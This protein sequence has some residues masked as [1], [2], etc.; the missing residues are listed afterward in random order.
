MYEAAYTDYI[1]A[2]EDESE[3]AQTS[4][5]LARLLSLQGKSDEALY[6]LKYMKK[7]V[8]GDE[9]YWDI[10]KIHNDFNNIRDNPRFKKL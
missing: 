7:L 4:Y 1:C 10:I 8:D 3:R 6:Y 2:W 5:N 9:K